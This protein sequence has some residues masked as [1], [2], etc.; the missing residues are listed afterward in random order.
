MATLLDYF[1]TDFPHDFIYKKTFEYQFKPHDETAFRHV[2]SIT[3]RLHYNFNSGALYISC[4][5]PNIAAPIPPVEVLLWI[6]DNRMDILDCRSEVIFEAGYVGERIQT[7]S[8]ELP[9][10]GRIYLYSEADVSDDDFEKIRIAGHKEGL[11]VQ[12]SVRLRIG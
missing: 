1:N 12:L 4:Y 10:T 7:R 11:S 9:F 8:T 3:A 6:L 5:V 2:A